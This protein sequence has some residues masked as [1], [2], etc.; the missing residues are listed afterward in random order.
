MTIKANT[1]L[2]RILLASLL[3]V[4]MLTNSHAEAPFINP[5]DDEQHLGSPD[6]QLFW[7]PEQQV[8]SY[9]NM[10]KISPVRQIES[11]ENRLE[12]PYD[13]V[14]LDKVEVRHDGQVL[15][16]DG[17]FDKQSVAG[18]LVIKD[19]KI[20]YER[21]GLGND[22]NSKWISY[23]VA[24]SVVSMLIGAAIKDGYIRNVDESVTDYLP[25][26][27]G[28]SYDQS[29][30]RN[31]LQMAS[32][33]EWD[34]DYADPEADINRATWATLDMYEYLR[35]KPR[36]NAPGKTF[37][38]NTAETNLAGTLLR[39]AIGNNLA[40][41][42]SEKIW[43]PFGMES[44]AWW[45]LTEP[46]GGEFGG[47]CISATLRDYGRIG[48]FALNNGKLSDGTEVLAP[49]WMKESTTPSRGYAG[50]GYFWWL[51]D[52][53][54]FTAIGIFGQGIYINREQNVVIALHSARPV[55]D[56]EGDWA[57]QDALYA[58]LT[59]ALK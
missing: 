5:G 6:N 11:G 13:L 28:S 47:C 39:S 18:L 34:E 49:D 24:K 10:E 16:I 4:T 31:I 8:A 25:Q 29:S 57:L 45:V 33:V 43:R 23:S 14:D 38:Y 52:E 15:T 2:P 22:E 7:T 26:L 1:G 48:L 58:A 19:G 37:N 30:I 17:Y 35:N 46:G 42:L 41:Y 27:K 44:D 51:T 56:N 55:A 20:A 12:L 53:A 36:D 21:Y 40:T 50:Y 9:R 54:V 3:M 32:G 59:D